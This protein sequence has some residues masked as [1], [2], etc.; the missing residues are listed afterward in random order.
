MNCRHLALRALV[1]LSLALLPAIA[2]AADTPAVAVVRQFV[3]DQA[4][5]NSSA[6]YALL[7][8][9]AQQQMT[10]AKFAAG[11]PLPPSTAKQR[12]DPAFGRVFGLL[13]LLS[14]AHHI[15]HYTF[16]VIGPDPADPN[17]ALVRATPPASDSSVPASTL[18]LVTVSDPV[19]H[20][21]RLDLLASLKRAAPQ[22]FAKADANMNEAESRTRLRELGLGIIQ[23]AQDHDERLPDAA[24][25]VDEIMPYI[26]STVTFHDPS[27]PAVQVYSYAYNP[28]LS[29]Q[30]IA[31]LE[32]PETTVIVFESTKGVKNAS[33]TGQSV[34]HPGRHEGG[35]DYLFADGHAKWFKDGTKLSYTVNG[36]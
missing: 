34:P 5:G 14:D 9:T 25:W 2:Q 8:T 30:S 26:K 3:A 19:A 23:Y 12:S 1:G 7:T 28:T 4:A 11:G 6:A 16:T 15:Q 13:V 20:A 18:H 36:K 17:T 33:D 24:H 21:P 32:S 10:E 35:T 27:A 29:H 31:V 22:V